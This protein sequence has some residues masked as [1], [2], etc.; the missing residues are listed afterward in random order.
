MANTQLALSPTPSTGSL[1]EQKVAEAKLILRDST[2]SASSALK[3]AKQIIGCFPHARPPEP[4]TYAGAIGATLA[5]YPPHVVAECA[6]PRVGLVRKLRFPPT[7]AELVEWCD[8]RMLHYRILA[9]YQAREEKPPRE[10]TDADR[11]LARKFLADLAAELRA[12]NPGSPIAA[13]LQPKAA[14]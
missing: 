7:V 8:G 6:D 12:R 3:A 4:E 2:T 5:A 10:F 14:E 1:L 9:S 13:L 11:A